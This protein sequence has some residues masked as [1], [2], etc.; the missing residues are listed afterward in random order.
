MDGP[1]FARE[2]ERLAAGAARHITEDSRDMRIA[3]VTAS[4]AQV[5]ATLA[6]AAEK[7]KPFVMLVEGGMT[8]EDLEHVTEAIRAAYDDGAGE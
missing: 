8:A 3:E 2:A 4:V 7:R 1:S 5:Y 6:L